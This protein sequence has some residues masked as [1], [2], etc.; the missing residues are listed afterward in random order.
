MSGSKIFEEPEFKDL[1]KKILETLKVSQKPLTTEEIAG[2]FLEKYSEI[3]EV[4]KWK[5]SSHAIGDIV[6]YVVIKPLHYLK[7][8]GFIEL[9]K[10]GR[11]ILL[12]EE[13]LVNEAIRGYAL[14]HDIGYKQAARELL[15][16][17]IEHDKPN[18]KVYLKN[19]KE[20]NR[21]E[22]ESQVKRRGMLEKL[23]ETFPL[24]D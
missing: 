9:D 7:R 15:S 24:K 23:K 17:Y 21:V 2:S 8:G 5:N 12:L 4:A 6:R 13:P 20:Y 19:L 22:E 11:W 14:R 16:W 18:W 3:P 10:D 1:H